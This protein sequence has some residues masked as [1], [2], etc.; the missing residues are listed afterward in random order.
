MFYNLMKD[1]RLYTISLLSKGL[2]LR[3][4][5]DCHFTL[6]SVPHEHGSS[7]NS[8][9]QQ[10]P[11]S[12][13]QLHSVSISFP[14]SAAP[15]IAHAH[16]TPLWTSMACTGQFFAHAPHSMQ[17]QGLASSAWSFP[18]AKTRWGQTCV[19]RRQLMHFSGKYRSVFSA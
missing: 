7:F 5:T 18:S 11:D 4:Q 6:F 17:A 15:I 12:P 1:C 3:G 9:P 16:P 8:P 10:E 13:P 14:R 2:R 19:Q